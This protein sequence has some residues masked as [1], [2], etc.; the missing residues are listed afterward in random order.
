MVEVIKNESKNKEDSLNKS[1]E[2]LNVNLNEV[3]Y[4][5]EEGTAGLFGKKKYVSYVVTKYDIKNYIKEFLN[6]L[7]R[8]MNTSFDIEVNEHEGIISVVLISEDNA[9]LIGKEGKTLNAIQTVVRQAIRKLGK[10]NI[11]IN[12]DIAGYKEKRE[13]NI[14][15]EVKKIAKEVLKTKV[16]AKL[17]PMNSYERRIVHNVVSKFDKLYSESVGETPNRYTVIKR[18]ED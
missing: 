14:N 11:K 7:A 4:Y 8:K 3:Y 18:K 9:A 6:D 1:L 2:Q 16:D 17:D 15:F 13:R 10:F 12:L 5:T